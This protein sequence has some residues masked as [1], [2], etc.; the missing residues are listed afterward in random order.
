MCMR[1]TFFSVHQTYSKEREKRKKERKRERQKKK[2]RK[3]EREKER[4]KKEREMSKCPPPQE[5]ELQSDKAAAVV[6][7]KKERK[8]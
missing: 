8:K 1:A 7:R 3:K 2:E 6:E 5:L 4:R